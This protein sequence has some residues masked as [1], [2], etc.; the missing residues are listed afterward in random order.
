MSKAHAQKFVE[1]ADTDPV[2]KKKIRSATDTV[3]KIAKKHG[4]RFTRN[5]L[6][7][8]L[9]KKW[10]AEFP[11]AKDDPDTCSCFLSEPPAD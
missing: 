10:N 8:V 1:R 5:E 2:L 3:L 6:N 11:E 4:Y 9:E 7:S